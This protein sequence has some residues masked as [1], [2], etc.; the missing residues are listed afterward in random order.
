MFLFYSTLSIRTHLH[1]VHLKVTWSGRH[2]PSTS[3]KNNSTYGIGNGASTRQSQSNQKQQSPATTKLQWV[4][5]LKDFSSHP[6]H[7][8]EVGRNTYV[9][10]GSEIWPYPRNT[11]QEIKHSRSREVNS[12]IKFSQRGNGRPGLPPRCLNSKAGVLPSSGWDLKHQGI[13]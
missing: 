2:L 1:F 3:R 12:V 9:G 11:E 5:L 4:L 7:L 10:K 13:C 6:H 8:L